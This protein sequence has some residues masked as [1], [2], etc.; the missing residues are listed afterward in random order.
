MVVLWLVAEESE[1]NDDDSLDD[2]SAELEVSAVAITPV[3]CIWVPSMSNQSLAGHKCQT[4]H[5]S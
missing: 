4:M 3:R 2:K 5:V 1:P